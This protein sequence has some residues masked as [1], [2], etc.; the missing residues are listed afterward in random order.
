MKTHE[1]FLIYLH[2]FLS[3]PH[4]SKARQ[5]VEY[6]QQVGMDDRIVVPKLADSPLQVASEIQKL[7][8][9]RIARQRVV[10]MG[11][12]LGGYYATYFA[13]KNNLQAALIN[14]SIRPFE[15]WT[16][17][18]GEHKNYHSDRTHIVKPEYVEEL[19]TLDYPVL[20]NPGNFLLLTQTGDEVLDYRQGVEKFRFATSIVQQGGNHS[21]INFKAVLP[22]IFEFFAIKN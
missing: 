3:S 10:L 22:L 5:T 1:L 14:P 12:S 7:I 21:F 16:A 17:Y 9:S 18:I 4:S 20:E 13:G 6:C 2:G 15:K 8:E 19:R 11:S